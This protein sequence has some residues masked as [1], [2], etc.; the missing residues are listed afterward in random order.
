VESA[1]IEFSD[2]DLIIG[3]DVRVTNP[4]RDRFG[5]TGQVMSIH[6]DTHPTMI[7]VCFDGDAHFFEWADLVLA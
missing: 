6:A 2:A 4:R 7:E 5:Q 1:V 3:G